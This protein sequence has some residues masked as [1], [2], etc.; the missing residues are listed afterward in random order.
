MGDFVYGTVIEN[1]PLLKW[2][3]TDVRS[4]RY[5]F[6]VLQFGTILNHLY[7]QFQ[8]DRKKLITLTHCVLSGLQLCVHLLFGTPADIQTLR[9]RRTHTYIRTHIFVGYWLLVFK[10]GGSNKRSLR[11]TN[12]L[13]NEDETKKSNK[14]KMHRGKRKETE[15]ENL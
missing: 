13:Q 1:F 2:Y 11:I 6:N 9:Y 4:L 10:K 12:N 8:I 3:I 7:P 15:I 14:I 5:S